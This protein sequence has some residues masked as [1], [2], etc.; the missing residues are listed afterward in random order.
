V[1]TSFRNL[2][3]NSPG[4]YLLIFKTKGFVNTIKKNQKSIHQ[5]AVVFNP[6]VQTS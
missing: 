1:T 4:V 3:Q 5:G 6:E 2:F